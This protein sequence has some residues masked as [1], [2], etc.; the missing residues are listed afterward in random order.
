MVS[1]LRAIEAKEREIMIGHLVHMFDQF[2][3]SSSPKQH[4]A[5]YQFYGKLPN[6]D[7]R[8]PHFHIANGSKD[9][10]EE[11]RAVVREE[12]RG[13]ST[14]DLKALTKNVDSIAKIAD[15]VGV[16]QLRGRTPAY[17]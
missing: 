13:L 10:L 9:L 3:S 15:T 4:N 14:G 1:N 16:E 7:G 8:L 2:S 6:L 12:L 5:L 17:S 11:E